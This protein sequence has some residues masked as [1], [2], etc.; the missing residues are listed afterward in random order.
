MWI[1]NQSWDEELTNKIFEK[2]AKELPAESIVVEY[3]AS[4]YHADSTLSVGNWLEARAC[5]SL[6]VS[7]DNQE[8]TTVTVYKKRPLAFTQKNTIDGMNIIMH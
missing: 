1:D 7:W 2:L 6:D 4:D 8:G 5:S 3:A